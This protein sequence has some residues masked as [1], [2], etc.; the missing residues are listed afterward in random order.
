MNPGMAPP[1]LP[2]G[3]RGEAMP[4]QAVGRSLFRPSIIRHILRRRNRKFRKR[5]HILRLARRFPMPENAPSR[6][7]VTPPAPGAY[8]GLKA[9]PMSDGNR[10]SV[11][12][13]LEG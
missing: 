3:G 4:A 2:H 7:A 1:F 12:F 10:F 6:R 13:L 5:R 11:Q 8:A 9:L